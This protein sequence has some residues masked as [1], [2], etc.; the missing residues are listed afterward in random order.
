MVVN[1]YVMIMLTMSNIII[2]KILYNNKKTN[3]KHSIGHERGLTM[4]KR[5]ICVGLILI[6]A[7][8]LTMAGCAKRVENPVA[9]NSQLQDSQQAPE[10]E[11]DIQQEIMVDDGDKAAVEEALP[12]PQ[13]E[14]KDDKVSYETN[15]MGKKE[16]PQNG[17]KK[18]NPN[19]PIQRQS[20][21]EELA[22]LLPNTIGFQWIY[23]GFAEYGHTMALREISN[24]NN[25]IVYN[26]TGEVADVSDGESQA[27]Y[28]LQIQYIIQDGIMYQ[29]K[30]EE[31]MMDSISDNIQLLKAPLKKNV[32]WTQT[33]K[34][35]EGKDV[36]LECEITNI[37]EIDGLRQYTV[38]YR[39]KNSEYY[40]K[41][42]IKEGIGVVSFEKLYMFGDD[43]FEIGYSI[44]QQ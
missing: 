8:S 25:K 38:V 42:R 16:K 9:D 18:D 7:I 12:E 31:M 21:D 15:E 10:A 36:E 40:E 34:D 20:H 1:N 6:L 24:G 27:D 33:V 11:D 28:S 37:E 5:W 26:I 30:T 4:K 2:I 39:D 35:K 19:Q 13:T 44:F 14:E 32:L 43:S 17:E 41:R 3:L 22:K 23:N 29:I